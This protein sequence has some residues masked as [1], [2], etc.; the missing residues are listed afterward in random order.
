MK[1]A[2]IQMDIVLG[3][4]QVNR[5]KAKALINKG[6]K[7]GVKLVVLPELWTTGYK[8]D[9]IHLMAEPENGATITMLQQLAK[10]NQIEIM[11]GSIAEARDGKVYNTS[12]AINSTGII[13]AKYSKIHLIGLMDE[14]K[15][16]A[17]GNERSAFDMSFG[18]A[19]MI[20]C[21]DLR[22]TELPRAL[23]LAGCQTLFISAE[24]PTVRGM[25][26]RALNIARAIENQMYVIAVNR[27]GK[28]LHND[29]FGHSM[30]IN[31]EGGILAEGSE[32]EEEVIIV[33]VDFSA[34]NEIRSKLR[35]F[36]D[37]RP[38]CY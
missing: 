5:E 35:V 17:S 4:V 38:E 10:E 25:H 30:V 36:A 31:P 37:R 8:L 33:D 2:L 21:Y 32:T 13:S 14:D 7:A 28:D 11:S 6:I 3:D 18:K 9:E 15:F 26:W 19:G 12:Y 34:G 1:I 23:A 20:I 24:W 27:V 16:I 22:F 29:F